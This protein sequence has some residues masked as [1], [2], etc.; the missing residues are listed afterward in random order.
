MPQRTEDLWGVV[1]S[2]SHSLATY[3]YSTNISLPFTECCSVF[4]GRDDD[5]NLLAC[6]GSLA[7]LPTFSYSLFVTAFFKQKSEMCP[8]MVLVY[9]GC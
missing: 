6:V 2:E 7:K 5:L 1:L 9:S 4:F 8:N 3:E